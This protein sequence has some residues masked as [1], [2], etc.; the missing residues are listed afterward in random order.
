MSSTTIPA[1]CKMV[2]EAPNE[3]PLKEPAVAEGIKVRIH[4]EYPEQTVIIGGSISEKGVIELCDVLRN[5]LDIFAW[6]PADMTGVPRSIAEHRL[7][8]REGCALIRQKRREQTPKMNKVI[9][10][11]VAKLVDA[12]IMREVHYHNWLAN[13]VMVKKHD[14]SWRIYPFKCFIDAYKGYHQIHMAEE[15][16][17]KTVFHTSQGVYCY[18]KMPFGLK[19]VRATYQRFV[20]KAFEKQIGRNLEVYVDDLVIKSHTEQEILRDIKENFQTLRRINMKLNPKKCTFGAKEGMFLGHIVNMKGIKAC[21]EKAKAVIKLKSPKTLKEVQSLNGKLASLSRFLSKFVEKSLPFFKTLKNC[22]KRVI[23]NGQQCIVELPMVTAP[24]PKEELIVYLCAVREV[25]SSVLLTERESQKMPVYFINRALQ[26]PEVNYSSMEKLVLALVHASRRLRRYF[27]AHP[28]AVI[29]DQPITHI[30]S[31]L[32]NTRRLIKWKPDEEGPPVEV[33]VEEAIPDPWTLFRDG[34]SFLKGSRA[35]LILTNPEGVEFTYALRFEF[36]A[37]NNEAEYENLLVGFRIIEQIGV[38]NLEAKVDSRLVANQINGSY[39]AKE[40][41]MIQYL[42]K[43][44]ALIRRFKKYSIKRV[45]RSENKKA[46][47][48]S[49]IAFT[50]EEEGDSW[51][52]PLLEYLV[53]GKLPAE[54]KKAR[55]VKIKLRQHDVINGVLYR[56]SFIEPWLRCVGPLQAEYEI[57]EGSCSMHSGPRSIVANVTPS[58]WVAAE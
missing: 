44:K 46:C 2:T 7:N 11:E 13:P 53:D 14:K 21:P 43:A 51:M 35:R 30:L 1:E 57:H 22:I 23:F 31:Q 24:K 19:N 10:E 58:K 9:Q 5:N 3:L 17:E 33:Q 52:T 6:K 41:S 26:A 56:K 27:H 20:D 50:I 47:A 42:E 25:V 32:E 29:T 36:N 28:I 38:K 4:P 48:L 39:V 54:A 8:V 16:E 12:Q 45:P 15:D 55:A 40:Q 37:S 49:K 18:T 34:L